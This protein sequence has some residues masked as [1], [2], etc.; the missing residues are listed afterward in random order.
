ME[1]IDREMG[2]AIKSGARV[3][4]CFGSMQQSNGVAGG[5]Q[6]SP[7]LTLCKTARD[8]QRSETRTLFPPEFLR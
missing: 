5:D 7:G 2:E 4:A 8:Q 6:S 3:V 1:L